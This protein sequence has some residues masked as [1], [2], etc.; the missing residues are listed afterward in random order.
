MWCLLVSVV[1][2]SFL[3]SARSFSIPVEQNSSEICME[4]IQ[5]SLALICC[6][7]KGS[8]GFVSTVVKNSQVSYFPGDLRQTCYQRAMTDFFVALQPNINFLLLFQREEGVYVFQVFKDALHLQ[9]L[10]KLAY[11]RFRTSVEK[12]A[13]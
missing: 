7:S 2:F 13:L 12:A 5:P 10:C 8:F 6:N 1:I 4:I 3:A 9:A 11:V